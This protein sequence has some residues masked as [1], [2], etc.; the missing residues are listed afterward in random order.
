M[1]SGSLTA[2][3]LMSQVKDGGGKAE[4][5]T[6]EGETLTVMKHGKGLSVTDAKGDVADVTTA[7]VMQSNGVVHVIDKVLLPAS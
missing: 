7:N 3:D 4:L 5:K 2:A 1:V 6:V